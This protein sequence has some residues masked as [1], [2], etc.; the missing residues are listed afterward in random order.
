MYSNEKEYVP[1]KSVVKAR[2][3]IEVWLLSL[4]DAMKSN[5]NKLLKAA[6]TVDYLNQER[7]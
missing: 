3:M 1:F 4:Q 6:T 5:L 7:P 2:G